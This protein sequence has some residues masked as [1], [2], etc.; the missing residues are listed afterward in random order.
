MRRPSEPRGK[1]TTIGGVGGIYNN[2]VHRFDWP[3]RRKA[4]PCPVTTIF[5]AREIDSY[6][7]TISRLLRTNLLPGGEGG[8][9]VVY[10]PGNASI[11]RPYLAPATK[12]I[13]NERALSLPLSSGSSTCSSTMTFRA[14]VVIEHDFSFEEIQRC[15]R[16]VSTKS[17]NRGQEGRRG[18]RRRRRRRKGGR[19][20]E[21]ARVARLRGSIFLVVFCCR[22]ATHRDSEQSK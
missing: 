17:G 22:W 8:R 20:V 15:L 13:E 1:E 9:E 7:A 6:Y 12:L 3:R 14:P 21:R 16:A 2:F 10:S 11:D 19:I 4:R 5:A 18:R